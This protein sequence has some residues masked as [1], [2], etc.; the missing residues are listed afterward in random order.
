MKRISTPSA[1]GTSRAGS[2]TFT[3]PS[4]PISSAKAPPAYQVGRGTDAFACRTG[5]PGWWDARSPDAHLDVTEPRRRGAVPHARRLPWLTL[6]A[7]RRS[8]KDPIL[9]ARDGVARS[10]ELRG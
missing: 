7:V 10:P 2:T 3:N 9:R 8:P 5:E 6:A 1:P 4:R